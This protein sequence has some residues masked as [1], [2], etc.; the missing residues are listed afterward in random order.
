MLARAG[1]PIV[2]ADGLTWL[3]LQLRR[4]LCHRQHHGNEERKGP[5]DRRRRHRA[6]RQRPRL[7]SNSSGQTDGAAT[8]QHQGGAQI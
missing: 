1:V 5:R 2:G 4:G 6:A 3:W 8:N 7:E